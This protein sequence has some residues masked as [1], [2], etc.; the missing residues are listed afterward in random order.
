MLVDDI[1][2]ILRADGAE[3]PGGYDHFQFSVRGDCDRCDC[4][5]RLAVSWRIA[6]VVVAVQ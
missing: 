3:T 4:W 6:W 5:I 1:K 2:V